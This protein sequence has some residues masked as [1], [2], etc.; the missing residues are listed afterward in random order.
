M[1]TAANTSA[2]TKI[3]SIS[4]LR[5][6]V[7]ALA[8]RPGFAPH[9]GLRDGEYPAHFSQFRAQRRRSYGLRCGVSSAS[10]GRPNAKRTA[11]LGFICSLRF[12]RACQPG[13]LDVTDHTDN[14]AQPR[15]DAPVQTS[16][17]AAQRGRVFRLGPHLPENCA[18]SCF[19]CDRHFRGCFGIAI[20]KK[21]VP[22]ESECPSV[23]ISG[24]RA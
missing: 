14:L 17:Q 23:K 4:T 19:V 18:G 5:K 20:C 22:A 8:H 12:A 21:H 15:F 13:V 24:H 10:Q 7:A 11:C 9:R 2:S 1:P 3:T 16:R 6:R